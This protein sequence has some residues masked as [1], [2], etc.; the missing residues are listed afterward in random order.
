[1]KQRVSIEDWRQFEGEDPRG[2]RKLKAEW[3]P[4][5]GDAFFAEDS[6]SSFSRWEPKGEQ[7]VWLPYEEE[8]GICIGLDEG[9]YKEFVP[10]QLATPLLSIGQMIQ[11]LAEHQGDSLD[12]NIH[13]NAEGEVEI[14]NDLWSAVKYILSKENAT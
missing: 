6:K 2:A 13:R 11:F 3:K 12:Y 10:K 9:G 5:L 1:M 4:V 8:E 14:A 7:L